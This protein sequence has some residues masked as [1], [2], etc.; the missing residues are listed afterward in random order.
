M[1]GRRESVP[2]D[3]LIFQQAPA[4]NSALN[5]TSVLS[6]TLTNEFVF[7]ASQNNL[8]LD[9]TNPDAATYAGFGFT[10]ENSISVSGVTVY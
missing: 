9:P 6:P 1:D 8:T 10:L 2:I 5:V 3:N 7:G 4:W